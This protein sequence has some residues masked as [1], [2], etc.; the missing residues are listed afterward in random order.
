MAVMGNSGTESKPG[1]I[2]YVKRFLFSILIGRFTWGRVIRGI[3]LIPI[4]AYLGLFLLAWLVPDRVI[5]RPPEPT[6]KLGP[7]VITLA[8]ADGSTIAARYYEN[9]VAKW[10]I[11]F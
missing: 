6:Y 11:F 5:F 10:T 9:P 1:G 3:F 7:D 2:T 8:V 4:C